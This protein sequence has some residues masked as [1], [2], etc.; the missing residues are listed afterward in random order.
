MKKLLY[1]NPQIEETVV[2]VEC[3][4]AQTTNVENPVEKPEGGW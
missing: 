1:L 4:F 3:G 2:V